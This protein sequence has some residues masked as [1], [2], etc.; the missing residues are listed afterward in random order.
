MSRI[1]G[2]LNHKGGTGKTTTVVNLAAVGWRRVWM[3]ATSIPWPTCCWGRWNRRPASSVRLQPPVRWPVIMTI[4]EYAP[5][6]PGAL[7]YARL[8][9]RIAD[10]G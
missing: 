10:D 5:R 9:E 3:C 6:S 7:D 4:Y 2:V 8:V 1:I